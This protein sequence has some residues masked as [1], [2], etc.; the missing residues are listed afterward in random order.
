MKKKIVDYNSRSTDYGT[1]RID[2]YYYDQPPLEFV[3]ELKK[4]FYEKKPEGFNT[5]TALDGEAY[6]LGIYLDE[7]DFKDCELLR[8]A[9]LDFNRFAELCEIARLYSSEIEYSEENTEALI[10]EFCVY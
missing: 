9:Y 7:G 3:E 4:P 6:A 8:S 1:A 2:P 5:R 10:G